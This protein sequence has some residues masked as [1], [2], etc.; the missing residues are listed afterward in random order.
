MSSPITNDPP[1]DDKDAINLYRNP[2]L[3][4]ID[5]VEENPDINNIL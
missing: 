1:L 4:T 3:D 2:F 5:K